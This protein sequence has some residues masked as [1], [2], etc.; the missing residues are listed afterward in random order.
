M[1]GLLFG[2]LMP[3]V[4]SFVVFFLIQ[5][6]FRAAKLLDI[7]FLYMFIQF[8]ICLADFLIGASATCR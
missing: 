1:P 4:Y 6:G 8:C 5:K 7:L 3:S 2:F